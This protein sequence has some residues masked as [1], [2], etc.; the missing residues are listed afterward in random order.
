R[1]I[2]N[3]TVKLSLQEIQQAVEVSA[4]AELA[5]TY[6]PSST[7]VQQET[8]DALPL[9]QRNNLPDMIAVTAP[10]MIRSHDDF[11]HVRGNEIGLNTFINGVSFWENPH[12]V[13]SAGLTPNIIQSASVMTGG[14]PAASGN[15]LR[16]VSE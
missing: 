9:G 16:G 1:E 5:P 2:Q 14:F 6:S 15:A 8:V 11:V 13:F 4:I 7:M 3:V 10:G 12:S